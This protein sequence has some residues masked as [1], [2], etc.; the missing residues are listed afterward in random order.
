MNSPVSTSKASGKS[1]SIAAGKSWLDTLFP[2]PFLSFLLALA[3]LLLSHSVALG[4]V[5]IGIAAGIA[6]PKL[7]QL[8]ILPGGSIR[9]DAA[10]KLFFM[11]VWDI[12]VANIRVALLVLGPVDRLHPAWIRIPL[13]TADA[14]VNTFLALI[15]T[16]TPGT[17]SVGLDDE[18]NNILVHALN[19]TD[20]DAIIAEVKA[21]YEKP[22][23]TIF[24]CQV[25]Q[26]SPAKEQ[27][28]EL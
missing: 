10:L 6:I 8:F 20:P 3:W 22:L 26:P 21:R 14:K 18:E 27:S 9:W 15:I 16:T 5:L 12:I 17:V 13:E 19:T 23:M 25:S 7:T 28:H 2:H 1:S 24:K 11:V 4:Q